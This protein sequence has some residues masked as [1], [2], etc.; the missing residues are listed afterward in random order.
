MGQNHQ[1]NLAMNHRCR[2]RTTYTEKKEMRGMLLV[3]RKFSEYF[4]FI[5]KLYFKYTNK[6]V[7]R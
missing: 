4:A 1:I 5:K 6:F 7:F 3:E 2:K